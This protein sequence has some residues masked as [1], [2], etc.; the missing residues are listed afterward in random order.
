M[1]NLKKL[2]GYPKGTEYIP[3]LENK[4]GKNLLS[5]VTNKFSFS[6]F[7]K[8]HNILLLLFEN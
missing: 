2:T 8:I 3:E 1:V 7:F 5:L 6:K 4:T